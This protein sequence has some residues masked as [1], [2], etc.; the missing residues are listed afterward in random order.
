MDPYFSLGI[1]KCIACKAE[2]AVCQN[3]TDCCTNCCHDGN[4]QQNFDSCNFTEQMETAF[5][6]LALLALV[7]LGGLIAIC[8]WIFKPTKTTVRESEDELTALVM[9]KK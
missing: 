5:G 4:C 9:E 2:G 3:R 8:I 1:P 7:V 6:F